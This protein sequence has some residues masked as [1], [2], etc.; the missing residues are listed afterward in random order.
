MLR[1]T[2]NR[3]LARSF[4]SSNHQH[5]AWCATHDCSTDT[6]QEQLF[7]AAEPA[8]TDHD[9]IRRD[10]CGTPSDDLGRV[11]EVDF[12][13]Q[14]R[15]AQGSSG[16]L[17]E[18]LTLQP[19]GASAPARRSTSRAAGESSIATSTCVNASAG[20]TMRDLAPKA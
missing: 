12:G 20:T 5:R 2:G 1:A 11:A 6:S 17:Q 8:T 4:T 3:H 9:E 18:P 7:D 10:V 15:A 16:F 14:G 19:R 13:L